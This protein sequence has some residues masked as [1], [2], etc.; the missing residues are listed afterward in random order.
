MNW[1]LAFS[2]DMRHLRILLALII[3]G[4]AGALYVRSQII[5]TGFGKLGPY[6]PRALAE[7]ASHP[8][9]VH[10]DKTCLQCHASVG[11][12]RAESPHKAV[13]CLHCHG[14]G[15]K[16]IKEA[17]RAA[18]SP[19]YTITEASEWDGNFRTEIDLFVTQDRDTCLSCH[20]SVVGMPES[21]RSINTEEHLE[22][23]GADEFESRNVCFECHEGHSPGL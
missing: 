6:R 13:H 20:T 21:F 11:E 23:Q 5:P 17:V 4:A 14:N 3:G 1:R 9:V 7:I 12:E 16:H 19:E 15:R 10:S 22:E 2:R 18:Q 8:S